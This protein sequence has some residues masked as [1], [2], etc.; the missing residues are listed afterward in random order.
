MTILV[1]GA[2]GAQGGAVAA[3]L[4]SRGLAVRGFGRSGRVPSGVEGF[5][6][7]LGD[8]R[9]VRAAFAGVR[10][11]SVTLPLVFE[12]ETVARY[13]AN[14]VSA[15]KAAGVERMVLNTA[16]RLPA[17]PSGVAAFDTRRAAVAELEAAGV[18]L[19]VLCPPV[20]LDNLHA[21]WVWAGQ[22]AERVLRYPLPAEQPV[23][24]LSH[25]DLAVATEAALTRDG[26]EGARLDLGGPQE[27]TGPELAALAGARYEA[28]DP[29]A[30]TAA[31]GP[32]GPPVAATYHWGAAH[33]G[34]FRADPAAAERLGVEPTP[35]AA[36]LA[37]NGLIA[38]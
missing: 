35:A 23:A 15:A 37:E 5:A 25:H 32:A 17:G 20:Y 36:W 8:E 12:A 10:R 9:A 18:P 16:N 3:R 24:W 13:T 2:S 33:P 30:F 19:V 11:V 4:A 26:L 29:D 27:L 22:G 6:G 28:A 38:Y 31:L 14:L 21:P 7:D 1:I 34:F